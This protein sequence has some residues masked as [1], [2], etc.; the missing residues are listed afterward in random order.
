[1]ADGNWTKPWQGR[2]KHEQ[3][4]K[5]RDLTRTCDSRCKS[6]GDKVRERDEGG[7]NSRTAREVIKYSFNHSRFSCKHASYRKHI[8]S[9][10]LSQ[11]HS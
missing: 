1:M 5:E 2:I 7:N 6:K 3:E 11:N 9:Y 10:L 8:V 4:S